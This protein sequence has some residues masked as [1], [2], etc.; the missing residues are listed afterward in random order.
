MPQP[1][2]TRVQLC[3][4]LAVEICGERLEASLPGRQGRLLFAYLVCNRHRP[5]GRPELMDALWPQGAP[6]A[7]EVALSSLLSKLR[8]VLSAGVILGKGE[9]GLLLPGEAWVD[10]EAAPEAIHRAES[11]IATE[12]WSAAWGP[13]RVA[14]HIATRAFLAG[15]EAPWIDERRQQLEGIRLRAL[16]C[17]AAS[18]L[19]LGGPELAATERSARALIMAAPFRESGYRLLMEALDRQG[20]I[21]EALVVYDELR[22]LLRDELGV[23]PGESTQQVYKRLLK[24]G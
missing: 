22:C 1:S 12:D 3:G 7:A 16:E 11:A 17:T 20:N 5:T 9:I 19:G 24:G 14:L 4:R 15:Y 18:G 13:S 8:A 21:A 10:L 2:E 6:A 23:A